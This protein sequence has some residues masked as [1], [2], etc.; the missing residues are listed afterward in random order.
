LLEV[1]MKKTVIRIVGALVLLV[2]IGVA[3]LYF[4]RNSLI[5]SAVESQ[6]SASL[7][8]KTSLRGAQLGVFGGTLELEDFKIGSPQ[9]YSAEQMFTLGELDLGVKYGE[10]RQD[11]VRV[12]RIVIDKPKAVLEYTNGKF[13][14]QAL[15]DQMGGKDAKTSEGKEPVKLIIDELTVKDATVAVRAPMLPNELTLTIPTVTLN[16]VG[17]GEGNKNG[18]A[19][20]EVVGAAMSA[21]AAKA[22][23]SPQLANFGQLK[24]QLEAQA[25][26]VASKVS[27]HVA[28]QVDS[29]TKNLGGDVGTAL[30]GTGV[31]VN[32]TIKDA[33]GGK[34]PAKAVEKGIG[35]LLGGKKKDEKK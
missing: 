16:G 27:R 17:T 11:P 19:I 15:M 30:E 13:N 12:R 2:V 4:Y 6:S 33:T 8:V 9:G 3:C 5:R 32:K 26:A 1:A 31:D 24:Q 7:G 23:E 35:D 21:L 34:D 20:R 14:F 18:A 10:L 22:A 28:E 29:I 25:K